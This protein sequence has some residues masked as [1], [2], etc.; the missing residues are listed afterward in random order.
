MDLAHFTYGPTTKLIFDH[1]PQLIATGCPSGA[2]RLTGVID[3]VASD[4]KDKSRKPRFTSL[5]YEATTS[6]QSEDPNVFK[7]GKEKAGGVFLS[8]G[9]KIAVSCKLYAVSKSVFT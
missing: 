7:H 8:G 9:L 3:W 6:R 2:S 4:W 1:K 5:C